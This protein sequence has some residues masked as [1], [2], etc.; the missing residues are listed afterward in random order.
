MKIMKIMERAGVNKTGFA[1]SHIKEAL[2][3]MAVL[4]PTH[5]KTVRIDIELDKRF[6]SLPNE[7][8]NVL[9]VRCK[10]HNNNSSEYRSV[11]RTIYKPFT[12]D[13]DGI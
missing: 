9:D 8:E 5:I 6:Y 7:A 13:S 11:P 2:S 1:I 12:K 3:E 10:N 4:S